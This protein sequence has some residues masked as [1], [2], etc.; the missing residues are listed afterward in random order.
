[1]KP[2]EYPPLVPEERWR[3]A[4]GSLD[5]WTWR[6][7]R[8]TYIQNLLA[9]LEKDRADAAWDLECADKRLAKIRRAVEVEAWVQRE[10]AAG[11]WLTD[12]REVE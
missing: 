4:E 8:E 7:S 6:S 9:D 11:R 2:R 10:R 3:R 1:M 5:N 12:K